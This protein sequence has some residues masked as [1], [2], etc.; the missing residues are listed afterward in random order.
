MPQQGLMQTILSYHFSNEILLNEALELA[1]TCNQPG[2]VTGDNEGNKRLALLGDALIRLL[3]LD[4]W[5][6]KKAPIS[7]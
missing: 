6:P 5:Y 7:M 2:G 1:G 3:I 4:G